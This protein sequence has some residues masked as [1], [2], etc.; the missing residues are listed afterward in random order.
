MVQSLVSFSETN[1]TE[2]TD[3][4]EL[5]RQVVKDFAATKQKLLEQVQ[6]K[7]VTEEEFGILIEEHILN[8]YK[9]SEEIK[10]EVKERFIKK[11]FNY[12]EITDYIEDLNI[13]DIKLI[14]PQNIRLKRGGVRGA[15]DLK[16]DTDEEYT[17]FVE[18]ITTKNGVNPSQLEAI[19]VFSDT[20]TSDKFNLRFTLLTPTVVSSGYPVVA[21]RKVLKDFYEIPDLVRMGVLSQ[22]LGDILVRRFNSGSSLICGGDSAGKTTMLNALKE[23]IPHTKAV[24]VCQ[25]AIELSTKRHPDMVFVHSLASTAESIVKYDLEDTSLAALTLDVDYLIIGEMKGRETKHFLK[26]AESG[27]ICSGTIHTNCA[28]KGVDKLI[29]YAMGDGYYKKSELLRMMDCFK[30]VIYME[31][32]KVKEVQAII[33]YNRETDEIEY[34]PIYENGHIYYENC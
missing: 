8:L 25:Q 3:A 18:N 28:K 4:K 33:G 11:Q 30:T 5:Y 34:K 12:G 20:K 7:G 14:N 6:Q 27:Q 19:R 17:S 31:D 32:F 2:F 23:T 26:A 29:D 24:C 15:A 10:E 21:I 22:D 13:C 9:C 1:K 16:F